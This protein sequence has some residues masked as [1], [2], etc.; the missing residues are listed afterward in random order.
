M[1]DNASQL[2]LGS[3]PA[4]A[5]VGP[6]L[7]MLSPSP[8][9]WLPGQFRDLFSVSQGGRVFR[10]DSTP[11]FFQTQKPIFQGFFPGVPE[12]AEHLN[13]FLR[14]ARGRRLFLDVL[15]GGESSV[16]RGTA[17]AYSQCLQGDLHDFSAC[18]RW[19]GAGGQGVS[20]TVASVFGAFFRCFLHTIPGQYSSALP[21]VP[22][23][24]RSANRLISLGVFAIL[25]FA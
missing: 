25:R 11:N 3:H 13:V 16:N 1:L 18:G 15:H 24:G 5:D 17:R 8:P 7:S 22:F 2:V 21:R 20:T 9:R 10:R 4:M 14:S 23:R 6:C 12:G 19:P